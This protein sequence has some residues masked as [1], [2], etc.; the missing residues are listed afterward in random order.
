M[1]S[2]GAFSADRW[3]IRGLYTTP[4]TREATE[5]K[6]LDFLQWRDHIISAFLAQARLFW[7]SSTAK[8]ILSSGGNLFR[9]RRAMKMLVSRPHNVDTGL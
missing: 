5:A 7:W 6:K 9:N 2:I 8:A 3:F 1:Y 4:T